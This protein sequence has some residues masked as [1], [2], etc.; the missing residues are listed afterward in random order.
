MVLALSCSTTMAG[1]LTLVIPQLSK[2]VEVPAG[3]DPLHAR[4][5][6]AWAKYETAIAKVVAD[7]S[8]A[9]DQEFNKAA[10]AGSLDSADKWDKKKK[11]FLDTLTVTVEVP[12]KP[13]RRV[14]KKPDADTPPSFEEL[15]EAAQQETD[16]AFATLKRDY[17]SLVRDYTRDRNLDRAKALR[18]EWA[19]LAEAGSPS[20]TPSAKV[21][22]IELFDGKTLKGWRFVRSKSTPEAASP[23]KVDAATGVL[24]GL[25]GTHSWLETE[26]PY[27]NYTLRLEYRFVPDRKI[28]GNGSG[29]VVGGRGVRPEGFDPTGVEIDLSSPESGRTGQFIAYG[30][31]L[32]RGGMRGTPGQR[33]FRLDPV[34]RATEKQVGGWNALEIR[35]NGG[36]L[37]VFVNGVL[38]NKAD[39]VSSEPGAICL[40]SQDTHVEFRNITLTPGAPGPSNR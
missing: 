33:N 26:K 31:A 13:K 34:E 29:V 40:R 12:D 35:N 15:L 14:P 38:V 4:Y 1:E 16:A 7:V 39:E 25:A 19:G 10:D 24:V 30:S 6:A 20:R 28:S 17:E 37:Q 5:E 11:A 23:W 22:D 36:Q 3:G 9:L 18:E 32:G 2:S 21:G 27:R 8:E